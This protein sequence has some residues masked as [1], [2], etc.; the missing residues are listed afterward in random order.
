ML[1]DP[2]LALIQSLL[3]SHQRPGTSPAHTR[4]VQGQ[5]TLPARHPRLLLATVPR[6]KVRLRP[7]PTNDG[8]IAALLLCWA[9]K[10]S[11][12]RG[13]ARLSMEISSVKQNSPSLCQGWYASLAFLHSYILLGNVSKDFNNARLLQAKRV[14]FKAQH[15]R[16][17][18][19]ELGNRTLAQQKLT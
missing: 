16:R 15:L 6:A 1:P 12:R 9:T 19:K 8:G 11:T 17:N 14:Q 3:P 5:Q 13:A 2:G 7:P 10:H 4:T 18:L